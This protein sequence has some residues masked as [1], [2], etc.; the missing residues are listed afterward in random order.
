MTR[1]L[2]WLATVSRPLR[3]QGDS[4][5]SRALST[6]SGKQGVEKLRYQRVGLETRRYW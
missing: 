5:V 2:L 4:C 6:L 1:V 3:I